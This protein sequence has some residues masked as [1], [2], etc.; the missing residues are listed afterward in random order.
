MKAW[1]LSLSNDQDQGQDIVFADNVA[2]AKKQIWQTNLEADGWIYIRANRYKILDGMEKAADY[3]RHLIMWRNGW[4]WYE[5]D[6]PY[7]EETT[8]EEFKEWYNK[9][10]AKEVQE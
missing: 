9:T 6:T 1:V 5:H 7:S 4:G 3:E 8:D 10:I 2:Q